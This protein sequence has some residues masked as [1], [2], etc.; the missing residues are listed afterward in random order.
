M[1][2]DGPGEPWA[3]L[4]DDIDQSA[5]GPIALHCLGGFTV[6]TVYDLGRATADLDV[7]AVLPRQSARWLADFAGPESRLRHRH[8][9]FLDIVTVAT[10]PEDDESRLEPIFNGLW[11]NLRLFA[12][13]AHD[14]ALT[15]LERNLD[16]DRRDV[17]YRA[18]TGRINAATLRQRYYDELRPNLLSRQSWHD[19]TLAMWLEAY[20]PSST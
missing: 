17:E 2:P 1:R 14:L 8:G 12:L 10:P 20:F 15:K 18:R 3:S 5:T 19:Q 7:L 13:E 4:L 6:S 9:V 16:R 11:T